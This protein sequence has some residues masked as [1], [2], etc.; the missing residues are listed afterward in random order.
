[1]FK[2]ITLGLIGWGVYAVAT[3]E[4]NTAEIQAAHL[5]QCQT[6]HGAE[7]IKGVSKYSTDASCKFTEAY[8]EL[9]EAKEA[10]EKALAK[11]KKEE[12]KRL[13][14][15]KKAEEKRLAEEARLAYK[16]SPKGKTEEFMKWQATGHCKQY[17]INSAKF[18]SKVDFDWGTERNFWMNFND[19]GDARVMIQFSGEM[20]NGLGMM[21]PFQST[22]KYD[23]NPQT[24]SSKII[25]FLL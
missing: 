12:E 24:G 1:M 11:A 3:A 7:N 15:A 13:A 9:V 21:I 19:S 20:M 18:P 17:T 14:E 2:Y 6:E 23:F 8:E 22:C 5:K 4:P 10:E 16:A 25:E